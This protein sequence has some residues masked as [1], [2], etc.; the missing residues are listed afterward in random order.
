MLCL[1]GKILNLPFE[2]FVKEENKVCFLLFCSVISVL[3]A[4]ISMHMR[5][6][7]N[8]IAGKKIFAG[9]GTFGIRL[10]LCPT[11]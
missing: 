8:V 5:L 1:Q 11:D 6:G 4:A 2:I 9:V 3:F 7:N 10:I